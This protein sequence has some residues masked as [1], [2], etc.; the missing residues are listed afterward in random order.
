MAQDHS[1]ASDTPNTNV[2]SLRADLYRLLCLLMADEKIN[3]VD[4]FREVGSQIHEDEVNRLL[5]WIA[6]A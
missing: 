6:V 4:V 3:S 1:T 5:I 2:L